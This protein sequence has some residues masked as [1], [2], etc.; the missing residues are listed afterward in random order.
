MEIIAVKGFAYLIQELADKLISIKGI[1][2]GNLAF[3][4]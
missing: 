2:H 4:K 1:D 3:S